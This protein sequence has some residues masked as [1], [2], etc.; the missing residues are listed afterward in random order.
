MTDK[1]RGNYPKAWSEQEIAVYQSLGQ[2]PPKTSNDLWVS[3]IEREGKDLADWSLAELFALANNELFTRVQSGGEDFYK[4][5]RGRAVLSERDAV[6]WGEEDLYDWLMFDRTPA[7]SPGGYYINDPNRWVKEAKYWNDTELSDLGAGFFGELERSQYYILDEACQR[8][9]LPMGITWEAYC[10]YIQ[11]GTKPAV[12]SNG[13]L[14]EDRHRAKKTAAEWSEAELTAWLTGELESTLNL[15]PVALETFGGEWYWNRDHLKVWVVDQQIPEV[16]HDYPSY[17]DAQLLN[18]F[19]NDQDSK[20]KVVLFSRHADAMESWWTDEQVMAYLETGVKPTPPEPEPVEEP[21]DEPVAEPEPAEPEPEDHEEEEAEQGTGTVEDPD[22]SPELE[23]PRTWADL[24]DEGSDLYSAMLERTP[25]EVSVDVE[26][27][28]FLTA[29]K[30][31]VVELV[32][33]AR[34]EISAGM[35][36]TPETLVAA[37]RIAC[38]AFVTNW[39]DRAVKAFIAVKTLPEGFNEGILVEDCVRDRKHPGDWSDAELKAWALGKINTP[40]LANQ[41]LLSLRTRFSVPDR[42]NDEQVKAYVVDGVLPVDPVPPLVAG[43][44]VSDRQLKAWLNGDL[45]LGKGMKASELFTLARQQFSINVHWKD[46]HI[47]AYFRNGGEP[48]RLEDGTYVE[49]RLR[50]D[51]DPAEWAWNDLKALA[52]G[53]VEA[54]FDVLDAVGRIRRLIEIQFGVKHTPWSDVDVITYLTSNVKPT[55]LESGVFLNDPTR[56]LK[57]P[58]E[59]RDAELK[60]WLKGEIPET[61]KA[62]VDALWDE[63]YLRFKVPLFWYRE[64]AKSFVLTGQAVP[65][66]PSGIYVRDRNRDARKIEHWTRRE[67]KA[68][69]R[70]QI[71]PGLNTNPDALIIRAAN[72]FG[73]S[74]LLTIESIKKRISD[75][76]E[77]SMTMTVKFVTDDLK[78]YEDGRKAAGDNVVAAAPY[79]TLLDRCI[80]RVIRLDGEDFVQGWTELLNFFY[81]NSNGIMSPKKVYTGVGQ[82][83]ITPKGL[84]NF[85]AL[86][87]ILL[88]TADPITRD[89]AMRS[90]DMNALMKDVA[91]EKA[92]Q[93]LLAYYGK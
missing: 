52:N 63:V 91:N 88:Q 11:K 74:T 38:G 51:T 35:N 10:A 12:T 82:M 86:T 14:I 37:L 21:V 23:A 19:H 64:D 61:E 17:T 83:T 65:A 68:W 80:S 30:W 72:L 62:S 55:A 16:I 7:K 3:D 42:L 92:R 76:T 59:W 77:E 66:T 18:L 28:K 36:T 5:L 45:P 20:A 27:R 79:Q 9:D 31:S 6:N 73:V 43:T 39:S 58:V 87:S 2:E 85:N 57:V 93:N 70:G 29:S 8:F 67:I 78:A 84:R 32:G 34:G 69:C 44:P 81:K 26:R 49:D 25:P 24:V 71:L 47:V 22:D 48:K 41:V 50:S 90:I 4:A 75:I 13:V 53:Q 40:V 54:K 56:P 46:A 15:L 1:Y 89:R 33:W 60:A